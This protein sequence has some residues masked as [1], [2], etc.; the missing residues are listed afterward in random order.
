MTHLAKQWKKDKGKMTY[1]ECMIKAK[2]TYKKKAPK[3]TKPK[4]E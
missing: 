3:A 4:K 1:K 2:S